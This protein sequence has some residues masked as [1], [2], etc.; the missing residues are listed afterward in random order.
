MLLLNEVNDLGDLETYAARQA[1]F[2][3]K[4]HLGNENH[5]FREI[6]DT[7]NFYNFTD[8]S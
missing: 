8:P 2:F 5:K 1:G 7:A 6:D 4:S 3:G